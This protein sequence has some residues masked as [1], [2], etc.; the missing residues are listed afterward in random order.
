M[1]TRD[2]TLVLRLELLAAVRFRIFPEICEMAPLSVTFPEA[3]DKVML[4]VPALIFPETMLAVKSAPVPTGK[5]GSGEI[6]TVGV[7]VYP[8]PAFVTIT[9]FTLL[10][11][12]VATAVAPVPPP[13][14][15]DTSGADV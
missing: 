14:V 12:M 8:V 4:P 7:E 5:R 13:P 6:V 3:A 9:A 10:P 2:K 15:I 11:A 1:A